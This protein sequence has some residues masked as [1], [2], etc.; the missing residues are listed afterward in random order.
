MR[1]LVTFA[2]EAEFAPWRKLRKFHERTLGAE[3]W[4]AGVRVET[5][6]IGDHTVYVFLTG[7]GITFFDFA[8]AK[9]FKEAGVGVVISSGLAGS[10]KESYPALTIVCP[11]RV[12]GLTDATGTAV[13]RAVFEL[14]V[15]SKATAIETLLTS[16]HIID[17]HEEKARLST[18]ADAVDMES[19]H[20]IESFLEELIPVGVIRAI[21]DGNE[22]DLPINFEKCLTSSGRVRTIPLLKELARNPAKV[23]ELI[24]F[25][26][27]SRAAAEKL[28]GFLDGFIQL[29]R[30]ELL[31]GEI[32]EKVL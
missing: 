29:L 28:A 1:V 32:A 26:R 11:S 31:L 25:G 3:H 8:V 27:Q 6:Q 23:P 13:T 7:I 16:S 18:F 12:V 10:L 9:C 22:E 21:S 24:R 2:V 20:I 5:V 19:R 30:P 17:S 14:A 4:S 15:K